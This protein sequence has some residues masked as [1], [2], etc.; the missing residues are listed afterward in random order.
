MN[1]KVASPYG[2][3]RGLVGLDGL[4]RLYGEF[5]KTCDALVASEDLPTLR[6]GDDRPWS[7]REGA[8]F[9]WLGVQP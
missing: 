5:A 9:D 2:R 6:L 4:A 8:I 7:E 1:W 3:A